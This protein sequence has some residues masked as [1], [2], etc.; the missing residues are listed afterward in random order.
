MLLSQL[1]VAST[2]ASFKQLVSMLFGASQWED[3]TDDD[4]SQRLNLMA[5][6]FVGMDGMEEAASS[7]QEGREGWE[8]REGQ[9]GQ[10]M[11]GHGVSAFDLKLA[12]AGRDPAACLQLV[13]LFKGSPGFRLLM[14]Y[15]LNSERINLELLLQVGWGGR[16]GV[17]WVTCGAVGAAAALVTCAAPDMCWEG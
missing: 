6:L 11:E 12:L 1:V 4:P 16:G 14:L 17:S 5:C 2:V 15:E 9:E 7:V 3:A 8:G 10:E 13:P